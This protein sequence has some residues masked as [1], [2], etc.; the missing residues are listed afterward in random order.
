MF[1]PTHTATLNLPKKAVKMFELYDE[2]NICDGLGISKRWLN[3]QNNKIEL[4]KVSDNIYISTIG[5]YMI[6]EWITNIKE[7]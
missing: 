6:S 4:I 3:Y 2:V 5:D 1:T 7:I